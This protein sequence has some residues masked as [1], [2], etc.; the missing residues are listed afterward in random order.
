MSMLN[1]N[2]S[3][4]KSHSALVDILGQV[5]EAG[6]W[7]SI[8]LEDFIIGTRVGYGQTDESRLLDFMNVFPLKDPGL[9]FCEEQPGRGPVPIFRQSR[10]IIVDLGVVSEFEK[11]PESQRS[12]DGL[13]CLAALRRKI[14]RQIIGGRDENQEIVGIVS[15]AGAERIKVGEMSDESI[16]EVVTKAHVVGD[17]H[18]SCIAINVEDAMH[19]H[20][21]FGYTPDLW[22]VPILSTPA[23]SRGTM[24]VGNFSIQAILGIKSVC[25]RVSSAHK[26]EAVAE[27]VIGHHNPSAFVIAQFDAMD[28]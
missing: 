25:I 26:M 9:R 27:A 24:V 7:H 23:V 12:M 8:P 15:L 18:P 17:C 13:R 10:K 14:S 4:R 6:R 16:L 19:L 2:K 5:S 21:P 1:W 28:A 20:G 22:G 11:Q 3:Y